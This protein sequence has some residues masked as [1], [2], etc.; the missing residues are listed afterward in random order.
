MDKSKPVPAYR[1]LSISSNRIHKIRF[2]RKDPVE[3]IY[4]YLC[5]TTNIR[6][7]YKLRYP[8]FAT[9]TTNKKKNSLLWIQEYY[10]CFCEPVC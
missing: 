10:D 5:I 6:Q 8:Y 3:N 4:C 9:A 1:L 2:S 7:N